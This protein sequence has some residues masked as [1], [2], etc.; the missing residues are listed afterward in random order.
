MPAVREGAAQRKLVRM[1]AAGSVPATTPTVDA[2]AVLEVGKAK[3]RP[4]TRPTGYASSVSGNDWRISAKS[5]L[6]SSVVM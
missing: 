2:T 5:A 4:F 3:A 6:A 1:Q